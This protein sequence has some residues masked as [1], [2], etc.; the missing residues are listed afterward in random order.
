MTDYTLHLTPE[1]LDELERIVR[2]QYRD[3]GIELICQGK[4]SKADLRKRTEVQGH[5]VG[6]IMD[7]RRWRKEGRI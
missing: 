5:I 6:K 7:L 3:D 2:A 4:E 1:E